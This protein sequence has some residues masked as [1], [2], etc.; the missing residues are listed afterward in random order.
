MTI[1]RSA[2]AQGAASARQPATSLFLA[3]VFN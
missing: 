3:T 1:D 2:D